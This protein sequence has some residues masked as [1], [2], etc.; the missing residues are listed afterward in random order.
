MSEKDTKGAKYMFYYYIN[1]LSRFVFLLLPLFFILK[2]P[3]PCDEVN[4]VLLFI[5]F[6]A[7][8][9]VNIKQSL[10]ITEPYYDE[11]IND[12]SS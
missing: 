6:I 2:T 4:T 3:M 1:N 11:E 8:I 12:E 5:A 7:M 9:F 10:E